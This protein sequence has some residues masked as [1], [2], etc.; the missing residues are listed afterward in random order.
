MEQIVKL[1]DDEIDGL[2]E[3]DETEAELLFIERLGTWKDVEQKKSYKEMLKLYI[4]AAKSRVNWCNIDKKV[5]M[6]YA[7]DRLNMASE[8]V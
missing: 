1:A 3:M 7:R 5:V 4:K 8:A 6:A 2:V